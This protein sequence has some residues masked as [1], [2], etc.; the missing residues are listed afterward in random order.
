MNIQS[1]A[2][3]PVMGSRS[4][5]VVAP[6]AKLVELFG[7]PHSFE[8]YRDYDDAKVTITWT[9]KTPRGC[10]HLRDYWWNL[11]GEWS[12]GAESRKAA[13]WLCREL[14][15]AGFAASTRF[16]AARDAKPFKQAA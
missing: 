8:R 4:G 14:R 1:I 9:I 2:Y 13:M 7:E 15:R 3:R 12:V 16:Y 6:F 10:V 11:E 5:T